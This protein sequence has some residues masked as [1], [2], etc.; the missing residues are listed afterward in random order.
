MYPAFAVDLAGVGT[1]NDTCQAAPGHI[2]VHVLLAHA[3]VGT[4]NVLTSLSDW[5]SRT[6]R[7]LSQGCQTKVVLREPDGR[8][9]LDATV[10]SKLRQG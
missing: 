10:N 5:A 7:A 8:T 1:T 6:P 2:F 3:C 4:P 9:L